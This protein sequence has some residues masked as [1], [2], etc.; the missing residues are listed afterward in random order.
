VP[1]RFGLIRD[2]LDPDPISNTSD[3]VLTGASLTSTDGCFSDLIL[4]INSSP[5]NVLAVL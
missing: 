2:E 1:I 4:T 5:S 3:S